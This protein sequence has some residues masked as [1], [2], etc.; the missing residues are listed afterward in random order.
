MKLTGL[1][2]L[3][4]CALVAL[5]ALAGCGTAPPMAAP[6]GRLVIDYEQMSAIEHA[7]TRR[8]VKVLWVNAPRKIVPADGG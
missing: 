8:G 4:G 5:V 1:T 2:R 3:A 7:A 6:P